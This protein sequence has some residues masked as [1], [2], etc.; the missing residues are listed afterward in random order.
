M[1][2][3]AIGTVLLL[4]AAL[5]SM[6]AAPGLA[7]EPPPVY[8]G[9]PT[10]VT[11]EGSVTFDLHADGSIQVLEATPGC[12]VTPGYDAGEALPVEDWQIGSLDYLG[13]GTAVCVPDL[14]VELTKDKTPTCHV[15]GRGV[16]KF[17]TVGIIDGHGWCVGPH[18]R[19]DTYCKTV[20][21]PCVVAATLRPSKEGG[22][23]YQAWGYTV[24][25][26]GGVRVVC[27]WW[28]T[29]A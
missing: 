27:D 3:V 11:W 25:P 1:R 9:E 23:S 29:Y 16:F 26:P 14:P 21:T 17:L 4:S 20:A 6:T 24:L 22:C 12:T 7:Q 15:A 8:V 10:V 5:L 13:A 18:S 2:H 19:V 28:Y